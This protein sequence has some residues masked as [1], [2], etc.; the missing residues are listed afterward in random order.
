[1]ATLPATLAGEAGCLLGAKVQLAEGLRRTLDYF[2]PQYTV[3]AANVKQ[4]AWHSTH[5]YSG[6]RSIVKP[7]FLIFAGE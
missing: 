7:R 2:Q 1:M 4:I 5:A 6:R 3:H